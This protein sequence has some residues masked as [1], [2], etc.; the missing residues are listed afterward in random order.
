MSARVLIPSNPR[1]RT[2]RGLTESSSD[3]THDDSR[4]RE[5]WND[6]DDSDELG[7][8]NGSDPE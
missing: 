5:A 4:N 6:E 3:Q 1:T 2:R 7:Q 8:E